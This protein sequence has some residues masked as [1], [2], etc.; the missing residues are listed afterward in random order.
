MTNEEKI[1]KQVMVQKLAT[2]LAEH[3]D[4][5]QVVASFNSGRSTFSFKAGSGDFYARIGL[6]REFLLADAAET[7]QKE[8]AAEE[9]DEGPDTWQFL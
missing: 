9:D 6:V 2:D 4:A 8:L 7:M 3:F 1:K 5:V